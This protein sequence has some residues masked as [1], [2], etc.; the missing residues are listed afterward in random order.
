MLL[1]MQ[2]EQYAPFY[3][4]AVLL[5]VNQIVSKTD[6]WGWKEVL[7]FIDSLARLFATLAATLGA[8][9]M[10]VGGLSQT[11]LAGTLVNDLLHIAGGSP[12]LLLIMGAITSLILGTGMTATACYIFLAVML[13]P[14]LI[15]VGLD[16]LAVHLY[17]FYWGMLSFITPPVALGAFAAA[18][19]AKTPPMRTGFEAMKIGSVIYFI[20][21][22]F[23]LRSRP[24]HARDLGEHPHFARRW[25]SS[26]CG[27]SQ[28]ACRAT[29]S[30]SGRSSRT[31]PL[32]G[33]CACRILVGAILIALPGEAVPGLNDW[34]LLGIGLVVMAPVILAALVLNRL[35]PVAVRTA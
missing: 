27:C 6:R 3:A 13:A 1:V 17:I 2:Q 28:A 7:G 20:P 32:P 29:L 33:C 10:I 8:V 14:A 16:P 19:V 23:V 18:S 26:A 24:D 9:G 11:G 12:Y 21:F 30:A 4:T 5:V 34:Q 15:Q 35:Q 25:P 31:G 22:F